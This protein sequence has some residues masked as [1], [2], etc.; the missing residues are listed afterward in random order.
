MKRLFVHFYSDYFADDSLFFANLFEIDKIAVTLEI[1][2]GKSLENSGVTL[3]VCVFHVGEEI[4]QE[5]RILFFSV[6]G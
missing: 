4:E 5:L 3:L 2:M 1:L 6:K